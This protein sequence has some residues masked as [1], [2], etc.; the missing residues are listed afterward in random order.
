MRRRKRP[1]KSTLRRFAKRDIRRQGRKGKEEKG[2]GKEEREGW[3]VRREGGE[4]EWEE[5]GNG[6]KAL[7]KC[8][9]AKVK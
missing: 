1:I 8:K 9:E 2:R 3:R 6:T 4:E 7:K 5:W